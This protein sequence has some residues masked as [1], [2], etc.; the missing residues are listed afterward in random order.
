MKYPA[1]F[2]CGLILIVVGAYEKMTTIE[3]NAIL[4]VTLLGE[5]FFTLVW[6][7]LVVRIGFRSLSYQMKSKELLLSMV[8]FAIVSFA[9]LYMFRFANTS[10][11]TIGKL[12]AGALL[13]SASMIGKKLEATH[14]EA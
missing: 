7:A 10:F 2:A 11:S 13:I 12:T 1:F 4:V 8:Q 3:A 9:L 6:I 14:I 5:L